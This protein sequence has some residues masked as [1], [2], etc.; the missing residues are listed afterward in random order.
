MNKWKNR[1]RRFHEEIWRQVCAGS[2]IFLGGVAREVLND[3][4]CEGNRSWRNSR[5]RQ[6]CSHPTSKGIILIHVSD[7]P[8]N[9]PLWS[10]VNSACITKRKVRAVRGNVMREQ[11]LFWRFLHFLDWNLATHWG[12]DR[13]K[14]SCRHQ[15]RHHECMQLC[16]VDLCR[17][18]VQFELGIHMKAHLGVYKSQ[19]VRQ[20]V[21]EFD[22]TVMS[23]ILS[24]AQTFTSFLSKR[25]KIHRNAKRKWLYF[26]CFLPSHCQ[27]R[28][29]RYHICGGNCY[30]LKSFLA[31]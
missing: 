21:N 22:E 18:L 2:L 8:G 29:S 10:G 6:P 7:L 26:G 11:G 16:C 1:N 28:P 20:P 14:W 25:S 9:F 30:N 15:S 24:I 31:F 13:W 27:S 5:Q 12:R 19:I 4:C 3:D 17:S 23:V